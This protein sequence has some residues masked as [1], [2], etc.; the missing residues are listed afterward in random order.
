MASFIQSVNY[1]KM[2]T[3][4]T[5][6]MGY[7]VIKFVSEAYNLQDKTTCNGQIISFDEIVVKAKYLIYMQQ[8]TNYYWDQK[9]HQQVI[10]FP[11]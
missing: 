2:N 7:Y 3:T 1:V 5:P 9:N 8:K 6:T 11:T 4:Y 10:I